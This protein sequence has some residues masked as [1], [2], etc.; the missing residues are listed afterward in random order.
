MKRKY[1]FRRHFACAVQ[2]HGTGDGKT[3]NSFPSTLGGLVIGANFRTTNS[4][5]LVC[6][7]DVK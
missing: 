2:I 4:V 7:I 3:D 5:E 1:K 6:D